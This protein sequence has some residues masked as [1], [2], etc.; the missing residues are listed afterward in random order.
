[1]DVART[2]NGALQ[3]L[4]SLGRYDEA[5]ASAEQAR[6]IFERRGNLLGLARLDTN[7][8]QHPLSPGSAR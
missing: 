5:F 7:L 8:G 1:M 3:S 4:I 6:T 2:L